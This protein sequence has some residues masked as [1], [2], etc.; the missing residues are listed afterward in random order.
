MVSLAGLS[1]LV[2]SSDTKGFSTNPLLGDGPA[3]TRTVSL[4]RRSAFRKRSMAPCSNAGIFAGPTFLRNA[5][6][7]TFLDITCRHVGEI[8]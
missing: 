2:G 5:S 1:L 8:L 7:A 6:G 4:A 3:E